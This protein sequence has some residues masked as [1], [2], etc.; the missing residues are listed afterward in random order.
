MSAA[1]EIFLKDKDL[2]GKLAAVTQSDWF[3]TVLAYAKAELMDDGAVN[4]DMLAGARKLESILLNLPEEEAPRPSFPGPG[5]QHETPLP[6]SRK[7]KT[8]S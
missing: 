5:L 1:K 7:H 3:R 4:G 8:D 2:R 6:D